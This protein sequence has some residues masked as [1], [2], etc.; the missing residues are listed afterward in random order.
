MNWLEPVFLYI[1]RVIQYYCSIYGLIVSFTSLQISQLIFWL[2]IPI[3]MPT[4]IV[5]IN[6]N[7][8][9]I[10]CI[11]I[12]K[13]NI[14]CRRGS[15]YKSNTKSTMIFVHSYWNNSDFD[16][17]TISN[18][19]SQLPIYLSNRL[20]LHVVVLFHHHQLRMKCACIQIL[21][22]Y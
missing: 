18:H 16:H 4:I 22:Y 2:I 20:Q 15:V 7:I 9:P 14:L 21:W 6:I 10:H 13:L 5:I 8:I 1:I 11:N 17:D 12:Y 19:I 3:K